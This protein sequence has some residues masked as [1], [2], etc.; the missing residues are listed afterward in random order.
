MAEKIKDPTDRLLE[1]MFRSEPIADDGFSSKVVSRVRRAIWVRR[2]ALPLAMLIGAAI[3]VKP[4]IELLAFAPRLLSLVPAEV[5]SVPMS[6]LPQLPV[7][8]LGGMLLAVGMAFA[9]SLAD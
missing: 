2:L 8:V 6:L 7:V 1:A 4:A 9:Q 5:T 3:A